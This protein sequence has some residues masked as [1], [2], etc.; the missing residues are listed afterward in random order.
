MHPMV[1]LKPEIP[2]QSERL[3]RSYTKEQRSL[4]VV[5]ENE[6]SVIHSTSKMGGNEVEKLK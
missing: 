5:H 2:E 3:E 1:V 4:S 6:S